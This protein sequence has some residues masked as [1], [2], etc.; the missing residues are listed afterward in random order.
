MTKIHLP[1][2]RTPVHQFTTSGPYWYCLNIIYFFLN[3]S[4][5]RNLKTSKT[6]NS[7]MSELKKDRMAGVMVVAVVVLLMV[8]I[9][10]RKER[11]IGSSCNLKWAN[12]TI[13][14]RTSCANFATGMIEFI[15]AAVAGTAT[16]DAVRSMKYSAGH[17]S[18]LMGM[19]YEDPVYPLYLGAIDSLTSYLT[20][21]LANEVVMSEEVLVCFR[22]IGVWYEHHNMYLSGVADRFEELGRLVL[23]LYRDVHEHDFKLK[24]AAATRYESESLGTYIVL[25]L[26]KQQGF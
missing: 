11:C 23:A 19:Y 10:T 15:R 6:P 17:I 13:R 2:H 20:G 14:M 5:Y 22:D 7:K 16:E 25:M 18:Y 9:W 12:M 4:K 1:P 24:Q 21:S 3:D 26:A 8:L